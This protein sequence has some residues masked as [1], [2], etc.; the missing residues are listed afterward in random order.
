MNIGDTS[1]SGGFSGGGNVGRTFLEGDRIIFANGDVHT[2]TETVSGVTMD[3][4]AGHAVNDP[5]NFT[6]ALRENKAKGTTFEIE[7]RFAQFFP[8]A[9]ST[10]DSVQQQV[11]QMMNSTS[12]S[13]IMMVS[14]QE[15]N[16]KSLNSTPVSLKQPMRLTSSNKLFYKEQLMIA[17]TIFK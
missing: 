2:V 11:E 14:G 16:S 4:S 12:L 5:I 17:P 8:A 13:L 1:V 15:I 9:P 6:P 7:S 3:G 10:T